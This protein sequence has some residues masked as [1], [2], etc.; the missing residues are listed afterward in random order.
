M[1]HDGTAVGTDGVHRTGTDILRETAQ[2]LAEDW[3]NLAEHV[4]EVAAA[5]DRMARHPRTDAAEDADSCAETATEWIAQL[6]EAVAALAA[7]IQNT[8]DDTADGFL[9]ADVCPDCL[10]V[11]ANGAGETSA[12]H[13]ARYT[14]AQ[15][16]EEAH[17]GNG[18]ELVAECPDV[19]GTC[20]N[21]DGE[22]TSG[23]TFSRAACD[24]CGDTLAGHRHHAA[25]R[26][27]DWH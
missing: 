26:R 14:A 9:P 27:G 2:G 24:W 1:R 20:R 22:C 7:D 17:Y 12:E 25:I 18:T 4:G 13:L 10:T 21:D 23:D 8:A 5:L 15:H 6:A 19:Y 16:R 11:A 3:R